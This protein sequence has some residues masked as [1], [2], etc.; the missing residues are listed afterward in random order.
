MVWNRRFLRVAALGIV[1]ALGL[2]GTAL[3]AIK[4]WTGGGT[5]P[6]KWD[7][8]DNWTP[9]K[10]G[11]T[12]T[13][14]ISTD[15]RITTLDG[16]SAVAILGFVEGGKLTV[17]IAANTLTVK[18]IQDGSRS[19]E[20]LCATT[21]RLSNL[22]VAGLTRVSPRGGDGPVIH[23][24]RHPADLVVEVATADP[25]HQ[26]QPTHAG[27]DVV[28]GDGL[29]LRAVHLETV[30]DLSHFERRLPQSILRGSWPRGAQ[31]PP[32]HPGEQQP[33]QDQQHPDQPALPF[34][35]LETSP[36]LTR[37]LVSRR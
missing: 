27:R 13:A 9:N 37:S 17:N 23:V 1:L 20:Y 26:S 36:V 22:Q 5:D 15:A 35:S 14:I 2:A 32:G 19:T 12:D 29:R 34:G 6:H 33:S 25:R 3:A 21:V 18:Q 30:A 7:A 10:P 11:D 28:G 8:D 16:D 31:Q 4:T 24:W